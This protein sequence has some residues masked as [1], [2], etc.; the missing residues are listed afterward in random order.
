MGS[1]GNA[2]CC[3]VILSTCLLVHVYRWQLWLYKFA[4]VYRRCRRNA[5][6]HQRNLFCLDWT[7]VTLS[8]RT[9]THL[10]AVGYIVTSD[11]RRYQTRAKI[12]SYLSRQ[13]H[14]NTVASFPHCTAVYRS[15]TAADLIVIEV[16][17]LC[18]NNLPRSS[19]QN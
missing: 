6:L 16:Y 17:L 7:A 18:E 13:R 8:L 9:P 14:R 11:A 10:L 15:S 2:S 5:G 19:L 12:A 1:D 3:Q 4:H